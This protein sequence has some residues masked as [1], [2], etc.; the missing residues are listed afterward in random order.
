M[1]KVYIENSPFS[2]NDILSELEEIFIQQTQKKNLEFKIE[3]DPNI[4]PVL[5]GDPFRLRQILMNLLVN[6]IKYTDKGEITLACKL[7]KQTKNNAEVVFKVSDTGIGIS[8]KDLPYIFDVF[9]QGNKQTEKIRGGAGLGLGICHRLVNLLKGNIWVESKPNMGSTF[10]VMLPFKKST[11][12]KLKGREQQFDIEKEFLKDKKILLADDDEHNL[13]LGEMILKNWKTN[14]TLV[15]DGMEA[16]EKL[17]NEKFDLILLDIHMPQKNGV[18]VIKNMHSSN[19]GIN[20]K[21]PALALTAN[22]LKTDIHKYLKAGFDDYIIKP[23][24]ENELYNKI[25]NMLEIEPGEINET[26]HDELLKNGTEDNFN[27]QE[28]Q[29]SAG[30]DSDFFNMM[31]DNFIHNANTVLNTFI[32]ALTNKNWQEIGEKAHKAIPSFK[33]FGLLSLSSNVEKIEDLALRKKRFEELPELV[34]QTIFQIEKVI[35]KAK[36]AKTV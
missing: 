20:F 14:Y 1:D 9:E 25:C 19:I 33:Y 7:Q 13:I 31:L 32:S 26:V 11:V 18:Q 36:T 21:T 4:P 16:I 17:N 27:V 8:D 12:D 29:K 6:A 15:K 23:F 22:A 24:K 28:L 3:K 10:F 35:E 2:V 5:T 34:K 30:N